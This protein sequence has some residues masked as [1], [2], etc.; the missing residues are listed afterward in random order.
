MSHK[1]DPRRRSASPKPD[2]DADYLLAMRL[3]E[4]LNG[5]Q[6][7]PLAS[8]I[9]L[10]QGD[11]DTDADYAFALKV[12][13][14]DAEDDEPQPDAAPLPVNSTFDFNAPGSENA[15]WA[16][17]ENAPKVADYHP[18][19]A[20][21][22]SFSNLAHFIQHVRSAKCPSCGNAYFESHLDFSTKFQHLFGGK[23]A[24]T[25]WLN[26]TFCSHSSCI[27]CNS[28][29]IAKAS[30]VSIQGKQLAWCCVGGRLLL[31]AI[32]LYGFD[33]QY[34]TQK[35]K[36]STSST[37]RK[38]R[39]LPQPTTNDKQTPN[40]RGRGGGVGFG[41]P[42]RYP[43]LMA[44]MP[45]GMGYGS[46]MAD[47]NSWGAGY[48]LSGHRFDAKSTNVDEKAKALSAQT[49]QDQSSAII[50]EL[51]ECLLP[52]FDRE[53]GFDFDPPEA[54]IEL[55]LESKILHY[56]AELLRNDSLEDATKRQEIYQ[57][58]IS[59]L[60]TLG[61]HYAT[62]TRA[63]YTDRPIRA[64]QV[65]LLTF[66]FSPYPGPSTDTT[67]SLYKCLKNL[68]TQSELVLSSAQSNEKEF[69][70]Q[71]GQ[72]LLLLCRQIADLQEYLLANSGEIGKSKATQQEAEVSAVDEVA[73]NV[74]MK[75]HMYGSKAKGLRTSVLGRFKR[76]LTELT[77][78][79]TGLPP[80]IFVRYAEDRPDVQKVLII[81]PAE[82]PYE[83]G[84]FEF[85]VF[86]D[87]KFPNNPPKVQFKT[88]GGGTVGFNPNLY[89]DGKVCL[90][91]L[92]TWQ[93]EPWV[94]NESTLL[95]V[96]ISIQAMILC[97]EPWYN[98]PGRETSYNRRA[99]NPH[100]PAAGYNQSIRQ[101]T[102][103]TAI[104]GWLDD[105][106]GLWKDVI[107]QH[108]R[109]NA[110]KILKTAVEWSKIK[111]P[112]GPYASHD[113]FE[114]DY[115]DSFDS[116]GMGK[117]T[118]SLTPQPPA[119]GGSSVA[120]PTT[121]SASSGF[122]PPAPPMR[123]PAPDRRNL[124]TLLPL[125]QKAL[126]KYGVTKLVDE[127]VAPAPQE[128]PKPRPTRKAPPA[129]H[130][131]VNH[132]SPYTNLPPFPPVSHMPVAPYMP[133]APPMPYTAFPPPPYAMNNPYPSG[134]GSFSHFL[135]TGQILG[136]APVDPNPRAPANTPTTDA[137]NAGA[138][139]GRYDTRSSTRGRE[140][141]SQVAPPAT[142][143]TTQDPWS[144][145]AGYIWGSGAHDT[146]PPMGPG[147]RG[148]FTL[149]RGQGGRGGRG[150][151]GGSL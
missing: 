136:N 52:S 18:E 19:T 86:C 58:L 137:T 141:L 64:E 128:P 80:G 41:G 116:D 51:V 46:D 101:H 23:G 67:S 106:P 37:R 17:K 2:D 142:P 127:N 48:A 92:G 120:P 12:Q 56:C 151:R 79:K 30:T 7:H 126:G 98:E 118:A 69:R 45:S 90:S 5:G 89:A 115:D 72:N 129:S 123:R 9:P 78:L 4:E 6:Q 83:N 149:G 138:G 63:I 91:L 57:S 117:P 96:Y 62:A 140:G 28:Q 131:S 112:P 143:P 97:D 81:G 59:F 77:T 38:Q 54:V 84:L 146:T 55:L 60:R 145:P 75:S 132:L 82:T 44:Q 71:D 20:N 1:S 61:A 119:M 110:D 102:V 27:S 26:C 150:G 144:S 85:D 14:D 29:A 135:G 114:D 35:H 21:A 43:M 108:F 76:L 134:I 122:I 15:G 40:K 111:V 100:N 68:S 105:T 74:V 39:H 94:P 130:P 42:T 147:G 31:L 49:S 25:S 124:T 3:Y 11:P 32:L 16:L 47:I 139:Q 87:Q 95:Q 65:N 125:L 133:S 73:A 36:E 104:L 22:M 99:Q 34:S 107:D 8:A 10:Q 66:F 103:R 53:C 24:L 109:K 148:G 113:Y 50:L 88:T 33:E 13:F 70:T 93:G 121:G